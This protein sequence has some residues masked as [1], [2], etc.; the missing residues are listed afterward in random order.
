MSE[1]S[2]QHSI[3]N[4]ETSHALVRLRI[5]QQEA[6]ALGRAN[7]QAT[8]LNRMVLDLAFCPRHASSGM[9]D[10]DDRHRQSCLRRR[11]RIADFARSMLRHNDGNP[12]DKLT[13]VPPASACSHRI[14]CRAPGSYIKT[15]SLA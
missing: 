6:A 11:L 10:A 9:L 13:A 4:E 1:S 8:L 15:A 2:R 14:P 12:A 3:V 7:E 5:E